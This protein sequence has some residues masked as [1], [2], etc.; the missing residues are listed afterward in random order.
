MSKI[1]MFEDKII[2]ND[3]LE[4]TVPV[5]E[6]FVSLNGEGM[7]SG[8]PVMFIRLAGCNLRCDFGNG[9]CDTCESLLF[10]QDRE[11]VDYTYYSARELAS[12]VKENKLKRVCLTGGEPLAREGIA[13]FIYELA[14][15]LGDDV[16]IEIETNGSISL[17]HVFRFIQRPETVSFTLDYK[18]KSSK[19][20]N[21]MMLSNWNYIDER[22]SIKFVVSNKEEMEDARNKILELK[23]KANI[24]FSPMYDRVDMEELWEFCHKKENIKLDIKLQLQI[25]KFFFSPDKKGV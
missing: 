14:F 3:K 18:P 5:I 11:V 12:I 23:P 20:N 9:G 17:Y 22:D 15:Y 16:R 21:L 10:P 2:R 4:I 13:E 6:Y 1:K 7:E 25:H 24:I 8:K 19:M